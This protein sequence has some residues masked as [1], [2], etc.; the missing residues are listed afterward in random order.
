MTQ[1]TDWPAG[2]AGAD[3]CFF[4]NFS[5]CIQPGI[6]LSHG[7]GKFPHRSEQSL[8]RT[9]MDEPGLPVGN[10]QNGYI[11][12]RLVFFDNADRKF[13][14]PPFFM[15]KAAGNKRTFLT[16]RMT[17]NTD[18][19]SQVHERFIEIARRIVGDDIL[20]QA[21]NFFFYFRR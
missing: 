12:R 7:I 8:C 1:C 19:S 20:C 9:A 2:T 3:S 6:S 21:G 17:G 11:H 18:R 15:G 14:L 13:R 4:Q 10:D 5:G 16:A